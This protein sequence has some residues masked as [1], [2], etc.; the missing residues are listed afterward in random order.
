MLVGTRT[1]GALVSAKKPP[2][3][4][5]TKTVRIM[6]V[7]DHP[8]VRQGLALLIEQ[9]PDLVYCGEAESASDALKAIEET[10]PDIVVVD[11]S[12]KDSSGI[13]LIKDIRVR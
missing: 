6:V 11:I 1:K 8:V 2:T 3:A 5:D 12:L 9:E 13:E 7:D 4:T 10:K